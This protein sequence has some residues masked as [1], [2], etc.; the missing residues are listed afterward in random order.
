MTSSEVRAGLLF[1]DTGRE[2]SGSLAFRAGVDARLGVANDAGGVNGRRITYSW[3]DDATDTTLNLAAARELV[4]GEG[5]FGV[6][7]GGNAASVSA[8]YLSDR[9][10]P[11]VGLAGEAAWGAYEN[12]F[13][14]HYYSAAAGSSD[15][16]GNFVRSQGGTRAA[17]VNMALSEATRNYNRQLVD[18]L[19]AAGV[20]VDLTF[21][22]TAAVTSFDTIARLMKAAK[23]DTITGI[24]YP[25]VLAKLL[26]AVRAAGVNLRV[27]LSPTGYDGT[28]LEEIGPA[29]AGATIYVDFVPFETNTPTHARLLTAMVRYAPQIQPPARD[30][31]VYGWLAADLFLRG[32]QAAGNCPTRESFI[33][34][35]RGVHDYDGGGLL[36]QK[37]DFAT[38]RGRLSNCYAFVRVSDDGSRFVPLQPALR[39]GKSID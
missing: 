8:G 18:S 19:Q 26:P 36:P 14:W 1:S 35:L 6:I 12:M 3:R 9:R 29:L 33:R 13:S 2:A 7:Q 21:E 32:L 23:I 31:A 16:W 30:S 39:C 20:S 38:N 15:V 27:V 17:I 11:V 37:V 5:V 24:I 4:E 10:A 34:G 22:V 25:N 28:L